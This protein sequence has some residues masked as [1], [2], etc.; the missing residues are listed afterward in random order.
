MRKIIAEGATRT[1]GR[2]I[3][4]EIMQVEVKTKYLINAS[5]G[6]VKVAVLEDYPALAAC[7]L[8]AV[9][10]YD[11]KPMI[12]CPHAAIKLNGSRRL[13]QL[14]IKIQSA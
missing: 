1:G 10:V 13:V 7:P 2:G 6:T 14:G 3:L 4:Q 12:S 11:T 5:K 9:S 8:V